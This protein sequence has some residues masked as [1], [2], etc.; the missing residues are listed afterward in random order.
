MKDGQSVPRTRA[1]KKHRLRSYFVIL[2]CNMNAVFSMVAQNIYSSLFQL[3]TKLLC[4]L[5]KPFVAAERSRRPYVRHASQ[6][7]SPTRS[8]IYT[9]YE[10]ATT[11]S[12]ATTFCTKW[13]S[14]V[15][16]AFYWNIR[17]KFDR[18]H[19]EQHR[20]TVIN[21]SGGVTRDVPSEC[22]AALKY[23]PPPSSG[24]PR[25]GDGGIILKDSQERRSSP[26]P[27]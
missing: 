20:L 18:K 23:A 10:S 4:I 15:T 17:I 12:A 11:R 21:R 16:G 1:N 14:D 25:G 13:Q 27:N 5:W 26:F 24:A 7:V 8:Q 19:T 6:S 22:I 3:L 9:R 2:I